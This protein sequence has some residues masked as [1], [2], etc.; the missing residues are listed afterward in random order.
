MK[1]PPIIRGLSCLLALVGPSLLIAGCAIIFPDG[2]F[3]ASV[4]MLD[5]APRPVFQ[6]PAEYPPTMRRAD[7]PGSAVV[8][9]A[10]DR[11]GKVHD[12]E[13]V[14][15]TEPQFGAAA[16]KA[17]L[18]WKYKSGQISGPAAVRRQVRID[19]TI[20]PASS[21]TGSHDPPSWADPTYGARGQNAPLP[22]DGGERVP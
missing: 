7:I 9:F 22:P 15:C 1:T 21:S 10:V 18:R 5:Q 17:V 6:P 4:T 11:D 19:F 20:L 3:Q 14:T 13:V 8:V 2:H 16:V 12:A